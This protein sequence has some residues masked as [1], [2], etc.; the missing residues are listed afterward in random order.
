MLKRFHRFQLTRTTSQKETLG[1]FLW[2][3][4]VYTF[5][6][7]NDLLKWPILQFAGVVSPIKY[8][9]TS[10]VL[11]DA[12]CYREIGSNIY[13]LQS[14]TGCPEYIYGRPL[15]EVL[16][17]FRIDESDTLTFVYLTRGLFALS[18]AIL[19]TKL[20]ASLVTQ[21]TL[22]G[23]V[24]FSPGVQLMVYNGNFDLLIFTMVIF[25]IFAFL[26][27][28]VTL[29]LTITFLSGLFKF[30]TIPLLLLF[31]FLS[32]QKRHKLLS[33]LMLIVASISAVRD[34]LLMQVSIPANGYAQFGLTIYVKYLEKVGIEIS[35]IYSYIL[36]GLIFLAN[37]LLVILLFRYS[38]LEIKSNQIMEQ[39]LY[40]VFATVFISCFLTGLSYDPRLIYMTFAGFYFFLAQPA[41][42]PKKVF[43]SLLLIASILSCGIELGFITQLNGGFHPLRVIQLINDVAIE[44]LAALFFVTL[45]KWIFKRVPRIYS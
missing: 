41:G 1:I 2:T 32:P 5:T 34:L 25:G 6:L 45:I 12:D 26:S 40:L 38:K 23:I 36:S 10:W 43:M 22:A 30:Y 31:V 13:G 18:I 44:F 8:R 7:I 17:F 20:S 14:E 11:E 16:N 28:F 24:L 37:V 19:L 33:L 3:I 39:P 9:D 42:L 15:L 35:T 4:L 21:F 29:G 27:K